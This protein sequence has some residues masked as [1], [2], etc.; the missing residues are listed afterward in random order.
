MGRWV[1]QPLDVAMKVVGLEEVDT[2]IICLDNT[3][4]KSIATSPILEL[5]LAAER[6]LGGQVKQQ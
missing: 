3:V 1:Y 2:Y 5:F 4:S 6:C